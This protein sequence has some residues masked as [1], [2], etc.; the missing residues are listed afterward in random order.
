MAEDRI[1]IYKLPMDKIIEQSKELKNYTDEEAIMN[2]E[3]V[4]ISWSQLTGKI[5]DYYQEH[6]LHDL[7]V[8]DAIVNIVVPSASGRQAKVVADTYGKLARTGFDINGKH[9]IR[10]CAGSGQ[11]RNNTIT[12]I[13]DAMHP[14]IIEALYCG[15]SPEELGKDFSVSKWNAYVGLSESGMKFLKTPPRVCVVSDYEEIKP[16]LPI[17]YIETVKTSS[18]RNRKIDKVITR[19]YYDDADMNFDPLNSFDGQGLA[20]PSWMAKVAVEL[21]Y[22]HDNR[23]YV[24]SEYILRAPWCKGLVVAFDFKAYCRENG[25]S[26]IADV[27]GQNHNVDDIDVLLTTSQF[28]MWKAYKKYGGWN[29]YKESMQKYNLK[30]GVVI[31]NK[32]K[33]DEYRALNYQYIQALDLTD[34]DIIELCK[35]TERLLTNLC[36]GHIDTV[37]KTLV[38]FSDYAEEKI[39]DDVETNGGSNKVS[40]SLLQRAIAHNYELLNDSYIQTMIYREAETKF[41]NAKIGKLLCRGGYSFIVSDPIAQIQHI[42]QSHAVDGDGN[43]E[44]T[45]LIPAHTIYS[46][47]WNHVKPATEKVVLMRSPLVD[48]SEVTVCGLVNSPDMEKWYSHIKSGLILSIFDVNT[49]ALQNCDFDGDRCFSSNNPILIRGAQKNPV[50][51]LYPSAGAQL[52]GE[53]NFESMIEADIRGLNSAVGSLSNQATCLYALRD[54]YPKGSQEYEELSRRIKIVSELVGVEIDKIKTGIP[55]Q[56]P[57]AWNRERMPYEQ[58]DSRSGNSKVSIA[59]SCSIEEQ[60][61]IRKHNA[62]IPDAKPMFM[63]YIYHALDRD[64]I[65]YDKAFDDTSKFNNGVKIVDLLNAKYDSLNQENQ[66]AIDRY[67]RFLPAIDSPCNMNKICRHFEQLHRSLRKA[68]GAKNM[69]P[70]YTTTQNFDEQVLSSLKEIIDLFQRQK[71]FVVRVNNTMSSDS[72]KQIAKDTKERFDALYTH[73]RGKVMSLVGG[74]I[75][76][77]YNYLVELNKRNCCSETTVWDLLG[78]TI[79]SVIPPKIYNEEDAT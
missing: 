33:D 75:Q 77:A 34:D 47:Y 7:R 12:Y 62:L 67:Y 2:G 70:L 71:R 29:Y 3:L 19:H 21:G 64:L 10:L 44:V 72:N 58:F 13:W 5:N 65:K 40:A 79:L 14:Y 68:R 39:P 25:V 42:I 27:Y 51:I 69:L 63:R 31:A 38:G 46:H 41:N 30:W 78:D 1:C 36:S 4:P 56:K 45:G 76:E 49:L 37:Y 66:R 16:H 59:P 35:P 53:I 50:P 22:L 61:R 6:E 9:Y 74:D 55:P 17:D 8:R 11:L 52:K 57:S 20:D 73:I 43:I 23:G 18:K 15:I 24:P 54:N 26:T 60:E 28:K 48:S 32:E